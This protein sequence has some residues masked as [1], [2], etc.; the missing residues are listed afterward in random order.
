[1]SRLYDSLIIDGID[2]LI[3][4]GLYISSSNVDAPIIRNNRQTVPGMHGSYDYS[5][6][7]GEPIYEDRTLS[8]TFDFISRNRAE[9]EEQRQKVMSWFY[10]IRNKKICDT[11]D[12]RHYWLGSISEAQWQGDNLEAQLIVKFTVYPFAI[13]LN[14][15]DN[16]YNI[17]SS[18][19]VIVTNTSSHRISPIIETSSN[20]IIKKGNSSITIQKGIFESEDFYLEPG[21]NKFTIQNSSTVHFKYYEEVL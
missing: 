5:D 19:E 4:F 7:Y 21:D 12:L 20:I 8:Y 15:T 1:M 9:M 17:S 13:A 6:I 14:Q 3:K 16:V 11:K 2:S 10:S 18:G